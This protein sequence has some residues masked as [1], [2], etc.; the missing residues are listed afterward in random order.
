MN[1]TDRIELFNQVVLER[2]ASELD[3][4][5][6]LY[7]EEALKINTPEEIL[8]LVDSFGLGH[9]VEQANVEKFGKALEKYKTTIEEKENLL[10]VKPSAALSKLVVVDYNTREEEQTNGEGS[11]VKEE[12]LESEDGRFQDEESLE[13]LENFAEVAPP[14]T[15]MEIL[16]HVLFEINKG[17]LDDACEWLCETEDGFAKV[18]KLLQKRK[19]DKEI[20][21][22]MEKKARERILKKFD[23]R[24]DTS[25][26][27]LKLAGKTKEK[28]AEEHASKLRYRDGVV[29]AN[30]G[31]KFIIETDKADE[32]DGGSR[33]RVGEICLR[34]RQKKKS[35][36]QY[37]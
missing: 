1:V 15:S 3:E 11:S 27:P 29:V 7:L 18:E 14:N 10:Q 4:S 26:N 36:P 5:L 6:L 25:K 28:K 17:N 32:Y 12:E 20:S 33:G 35:K 30:K 16:Y 37:V 2:N 9:S 22:V 21:M 24:I 8:S 13:K 23:L 34:K 19:E 31:E